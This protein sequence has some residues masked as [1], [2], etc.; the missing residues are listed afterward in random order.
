MGKAE[1]ITTEK[2]KAKNHER[3]EEEIEEEEKEEEIEEMKEIRNQEKTEVEVKTNLKDIVTVENDEEESKKDTKMETNVNI[4]ADNNT[5]NSGKVRKEEAPTIHATADKS[6]SSKQLIYKEDDLPHINIKSISQ[7]E[8]YLQTSFSSSSSLSYGLFNNA[9][10][11]LSNG[12]GPS[13]LNMTITERIQN[14]KTG[15]EFVVG[16]PVDTPFYIVDKDC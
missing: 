16:V 15:E 3:E 11:D 10:P 4:S 8:A 12:T 2:P 9:M 13:F 5:K 1:V 7:P 14:T 6:P